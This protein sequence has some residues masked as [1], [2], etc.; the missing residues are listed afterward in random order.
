M[1]AYSFV[2]P[3]IYDRLEWGGDFMGMGFDRTNV[4]V[5]G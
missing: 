3:G 1:N 4:Q 5:L 2:R